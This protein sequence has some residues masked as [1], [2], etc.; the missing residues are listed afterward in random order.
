MSDDQALREIL[1]NMLR[2][3]KLIRAAVDR[4]ARLERPPQPAVRD[5]PK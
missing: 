1:V 3:L 5:F 4:I 2:E